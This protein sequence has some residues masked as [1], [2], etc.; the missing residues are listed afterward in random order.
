MGSVEGS[1]AAIQS[2]DA[3]PTILKVAVKTTGMRFAA[4]ARVTEDEWLACATH[5][6]A[7]FGLVAGDMLPIG[8]TLCQEV[9]RLGLPIAIDEVAT[10]DV[11]RDHPT[12]AAFGFQSY[13]SVPIVRGDGSIFGTLCALDPEPRA[14]KRP[15]V[16]DSFRLF[17]DL[18]ARH[19]DARERLET[20]QAALVEERALAGLRDRFV[21]VLGHDLRNPLAAIEA[22]ATLL[23]RATLD[24]RSTAIV[25]RMRQ[26]T[27]RMAEL[28]DDVLDLARGQMGGGL[29]IAS[30]A[31]AALGDALGLVVSE[32]RA[33]HPDR[34]ILADLAITATVACDPRRIMQLL[35]N[36]LANALT[37]GDA[38][39]P[40]R[41]EAGCAKGRFVMAVANGGAAIP[42]EQLPQLFEPFSRSAK[43]RDGL[44]LGL[45]IAAEIAKA[46]DGRIEVTSTD[47]ETRFT[48]SMPQFPA[49]DAAA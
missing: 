21:A 23:A 20:A 17:A 30:A 13:L 6:E 40:V 27:R 7:S 46:H 38:A 5:D 4:I 47:Q 14:A 10:D 44:G 2:I 28:I 33:V 9:R 25:G 29:Q 19:L 45:Y 42:A 16:L 48:F 36:L 32:L 35:S 41:V 24:D 18:I 12:P 49:M 26:S 39:Q 3:V 37:H 34:V 11:Y 8:T 22:G 43:S 31:D 1:L 15:E